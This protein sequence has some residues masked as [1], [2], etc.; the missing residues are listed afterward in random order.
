[1]LLLAGLILVFISSVAP[2]SDPASDLTLDRAGHFVVYGIVSIL[3]CRH[4]TRKDRSRRSVLRAMPSATAYG[5]GMDAMQYFLPMR[6]FSVADMIAK[7]LGAAS[8][9]MVHDQWETRQS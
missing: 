4:F 8:F 1:M 6:Q 5:A 9:R 3:F 2:V 7:A